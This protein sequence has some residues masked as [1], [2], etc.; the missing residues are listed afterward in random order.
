MSDQ[1][2]KRESMPTEEATISN[3]WEIAE[4]QQLAREWKQKGK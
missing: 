2:P 1:C 4:E 3:M